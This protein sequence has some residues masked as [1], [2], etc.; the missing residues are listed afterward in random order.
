LASS[1]AWGGLARSCAPPQPRQCGRQRVLTDSYTGMMHRC[2]VHRRDSWAHPKCTCTDGWCRWRAVGRGVAWHA[3]A[4][5][6]SRGSAAGS[7]SWART[8]ASLP[9]CPA[10]A[11]SD[12]RRRPR[13]R[14]GALRA[15]ARGARTSGICRIPVFRYG[16]H[17]KSNLV[18]DSI[19]PVSNKSVELTKDMLI[20]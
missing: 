20:Q 16:F 1:G 4:R 12:T 11:A 18:W 13:G 3:A 17:S 19:K 5:P 10:S 2:V 15:A 9:R 8:G 14:S 7:A 6:P